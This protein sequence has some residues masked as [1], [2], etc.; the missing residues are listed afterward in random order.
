M[1]AWVGTCHKKGVSFSEVVWD[2][3]NI[4]PLYKFWEEAL[5]HLSGKGSLLVWK[6]VVKLPLPGTGVP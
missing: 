6:G 2:A 4:F 1:L 5:M 3:G